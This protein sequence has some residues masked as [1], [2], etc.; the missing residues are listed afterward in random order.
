[1]MPVPAH[2]CCSPPCWSPPAPALRSPM[3]LAPAMLLAL[4]ALQPTRVMWKPAAGQR[5]AVPHE[6]KAV[7]S[8]VTEM[9]SSLPWVFQMVVT[10]AAKHTRFA[11]AAADWM[12]VPHYCWKSLQIWR[13]SSPTHHARVL[14]LPPAHAVLRGPLP[15]HLPIF[16][17]GAA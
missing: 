17:S 12:C 10:E 1:M 15:E 7:A 4:M 9:W 6:Q 8:L 14:R 11:D 2:Q 3:V 16:W 5:G 13:T